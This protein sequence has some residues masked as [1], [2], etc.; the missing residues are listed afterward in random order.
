MWEWDF[1]RK[2]NFVV[3]LVLWWLRACLEEMSL[4]TG[5]SLLKEA[6]VSGHREF[7]VHGKHQG[8]SEFAGKCGRF[9][10][11]QTNVFRSIGT[12]QWTVL[13]QSKGRTIHYIWCWKFLL[14][15][16]VFVGDHFWLHKK[17]TM[18][19]SDLE[20]DPNS[21]AFFSQSLIRTLLF[22]IHLLFREQKQVF[23]YLLYAR[24]YSRCF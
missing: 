18:W 7:T 8:T 17:G 13:P 20:T 23:K 11:K 4:Q 1:S 15:R 10:V 12:E 24:H 14:I 16:S 22:L 6:L 3:S 19:R 2:G 5:D 9:K 21:T